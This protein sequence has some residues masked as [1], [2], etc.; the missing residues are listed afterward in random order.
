M[1]DLIQLFSL[2]TLIQREANDILQIHV[3]IYEN[4][5]QV[6]DAVFLKVSF[7]LTFNQNWTLSFAF[8]ILVFKWL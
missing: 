5:M 2:L 7:K 8:S 3:V 4:E 1:S 6:T